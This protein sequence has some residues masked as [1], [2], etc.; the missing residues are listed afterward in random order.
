MQQPL[1]LLLEVHQL[2]SGCTLKRPMFY[3]QILI[4][5]YHNSL[6][7]D[8]INR[9]TAVGCFMSN[10]LRRRCVAIFSI[11]RLLPMQYAFYGA[12][13]VLDLGLG[14]WNVRHVRPK[15]HGYFHLVWEVAAFN[16]EANERRICDFIWCGHAFGLLLTHA[17]SPT[18]INSHANRVSASKNRG[19]E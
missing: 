3:G 4:P 10:W 14:G 13:A 18:S 2:N 6:E 17:K 9:I 19:C 7:H 12:D 5:H 1:L 15:L 8:S 16:K 11:A